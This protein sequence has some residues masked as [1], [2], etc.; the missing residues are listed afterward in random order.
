V[1]IAVKS[2]YNSETVHDLDSNC[3]VV[4]AKF[5]LKGNG[6]VYIGSYYRRHVSDGESLE[7][8]ETSLHRA[9]SI[10]NASIIIGG[11]FNLP[12]WD[13]RSTTLKANAAY[14]NLHQQF[15]DI[16]NNNGLA[17]IVE[18]PTGLDNT[19]DLILTNSPSKVLQTTLYQ[20]SQIMTMFIP[21]LTLGMSYTA[22]HH[23]AFLYITKLTVTPS[24]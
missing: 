19:L 6:T 20:A 13:W 1:L 3:E 14:P 16:I 15:L 7:Q 17:Q 24:D 11:D 8:L 9:S 5:N 18:D 10:R 22:K 4:W 2:E 23:A 12:G 21:N